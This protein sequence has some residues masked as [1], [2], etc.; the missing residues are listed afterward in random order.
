MNLPMD[1]QQKNHTIILEGLV[2]EGNLSGTG[3]ITIAGELKGNMDF[4]GESECVIEPSGVINGNCSLDSIIVKGKL[5]GNVSARRLVTL[6]KSGVIEGDI[7]VLK[8]TIAEGASVFGKL[9]VES[10]KKSE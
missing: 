9:N 10:P 1:G 7:T 8:I 4:D 5:K 2:I 3:D 6:E